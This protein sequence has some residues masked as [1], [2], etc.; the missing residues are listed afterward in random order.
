MSATF[1]EAAARAATAYEAL[2]SLAESVEDEWQYV[3][4]LL[5]EYLPGIQAL[6]GPDPHAPLTYEAAAAV[7]E[8]VAEI[9]LIA[10]PH[11]AIDWLSTFP[12]VVALAL[13]P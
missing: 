7:D 3:N 1:G 4:D 5:D 13:R 2:A 10:D 11:K 12:Y 8:V 6:A 9:G